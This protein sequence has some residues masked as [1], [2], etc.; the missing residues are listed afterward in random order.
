MSQGHGTDDVAAGLGVPER[1]AQRFAELVAVM[2]RLRSPGG[3][4][5]DGQQ[6]HESLVRYLVEEAYEV[7]EA[8]E[9][10]G[11]PA[12][13]AGLLVEELGDVLLQVVFHARVAQER[14]RVEGGFDVADVLEAVTA[15][16][17]RR[18][19][20][21][22]DVGATG[23]VAGEQS[24]EQ[25][26]S[27]WEDLKRAEKPE[28]TGPFDGI[29]PHL[30]ALA[31]AEKTLA[32]ARKHDLEPAVPD[33]EEPGGP[34]TEEELGEALFALV[35]TASARG[36]DAERALRGAARAYAAGRNGN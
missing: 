33:A 36:L 16:L 3:C 21:V 5:W 10:E 30:P 34:R 17:V 8:V 26:H 19:P 1:T 12:A 15:K 32:R 31:L 20:H 24:L 14:P 7:V 27:R 18:H 35:R 28:R 4:A 2:D 11:G 22:F 23:D 25:L 9:A 6:T 29:P 13:H